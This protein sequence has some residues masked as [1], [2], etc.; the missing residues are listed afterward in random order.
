MP[1]TR[2]VFTPGATTAYMVTDVAGDG[3]SARPYCFLYAIDLSSSSNTP[4]SVS[5]VATTSTTIP[6]GGQITVKGTFTDPDPNDGPWSYTFRWQN[7][8]TSGTAAAPGS[9][10]QTR[11]YS[12]AGTFAIRLRVTDAR[13]ALGISNAVTVNVQ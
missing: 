11:T 13:G 8:P 3:A 12:T 9:I 10:T 1:T 4:P 2:P 7:G 6:R 5:L